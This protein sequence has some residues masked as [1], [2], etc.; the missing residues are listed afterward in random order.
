MSCS[1]LMKT[2]FATAL[3]ASLL[4]TAAATAQLAVADVEVSAGGTS[5]STA[6]VQVTID[7]RWP[8][9]GL[10]EPLSLRLSGGMLL[11]SGEERDGNAA[12][13]VSPA[14]RWT[15]AGG[16]GIFMEGGIGAALFLE[17][18]V[19]GRKLSTAYQ[20]EDRLALGLPWASGELALALTHY[21]NAGIKRPND[22]F[23]TLT[24]GYRFPL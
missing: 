20:F 4:F 13:T 5:E 18:R 6:A 17:T 12:L 24:L 10:N 11:L 3:L 2:G 1:M 7:R 9:E 23:E 15:F 22:G 14:L 19:E 21:S 16:R 8:L